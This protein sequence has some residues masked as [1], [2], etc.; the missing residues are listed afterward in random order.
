MTSFSL[1]LQS[2][3]VFVLT[4]AC[5]AVW[6]FVAKHPFDNI[7][8]PDRESLW[9][10]NIGQIFNPYGWDFHQMLREKYG[11]V[12]MFHGLF[13]SKQLYVYDPKAMHRIFVE[14]QYV[15]EETASYLETNKLVFGNGLLSTLGDHHKRQRKMLNPVFSTSHMRHMVP[16]FRE[17]TAT[18]RDVFANQVKD[19]PREINMLEWFTRTA[20]ELIGQSGL[21]Y[22]FDSLKEGAANP[23][24]TAVKNLMPGLFKLF[25]AHK[26]LPLVVGIG[27]PGFRRFLVKITPWKALREI[28]SIV[29]IMDQTST[30]VFRSKKLALEQGDEAIVQ[31]VGQGKDIMSILLKANMAASEQDRLPESELLAQMSTLVFSAMDTTSGALARTFLTLACHPD[32]QERL[33]QEVQ[34]VRAEKG[35]LDYDDLVNLP[36]LDA[37]CRETLRLYPPVTWVHRTTRKDS[38]L[39]FGKPIRG[40]DGKEMH[41]VLVPKGT[42]VIVSVLASNINPEIWGEDALEW[43][44]ERWLAPLPASVADAGIPGVFSHLMTFIGGGRACI[45]FKFSQLEMKVVLSTLI[46]SFKFTPSKEIVW[47]MGFLS[48]PKVKDSQDGKFQLPLTV[49]LVEGG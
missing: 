9:K 44:P 19:G 7:P 36:Y 23:Y 4:S 37:V 6:K 46:E 13:G 29:D 38:V 5:W 40:L 49:E 39:P 10:G 3:L 24:S 47:S 12:S 28:D 16:I 34:Q 17:I 30:E 11:P 32:A 48:T 43:K 27:P 25:I 14:A 41:D 8:G 31:Q 26:L 1:I 15:Y 42:T 33:R 35:D 18:L 2:I 20:L 21:G 22:S 45:G